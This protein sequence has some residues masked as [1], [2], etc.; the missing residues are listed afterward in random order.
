[1][2]EGMT[3][4]E[5]A[6]IKALVDAWNAFVDLPVQHADDV[7]EFRRII[8][9][10]QEKVFARPMVRAYANVPRWPSVI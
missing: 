7:H 9:A 6:V 2:A 5:V 1:M 8:H 10:A 4:A 3:E